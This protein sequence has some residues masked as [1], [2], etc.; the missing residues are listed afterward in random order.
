MW[1]V[2]HAHDSLPIVEF[3]R[4]MRLWSGGEAV[5]MMRDGM[6]ENGLGEEDGGISASL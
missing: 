5:E 4:S 3:D 6:G 2:K 1:L